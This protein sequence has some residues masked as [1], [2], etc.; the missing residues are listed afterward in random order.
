MF[1]EVFES[2]YEQLPE[3]ITNNRVFEEILKT[4]MGQIPENL[5]LD[6]ILLCVSPEIFANTK[7]MA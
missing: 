2:V 4:I 6:K 7:Y 5:S 1:K 3:E